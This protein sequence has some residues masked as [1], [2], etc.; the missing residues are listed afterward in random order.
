MSHI[1]VASICARMGLCD[2]ERNM[3]TLRRWCV[4]ARKAGADL[5]VFPEIFISGYAENFMC[6][7]GYADRKTF[8]SL[9]EK[10]PG[11]STQ[12]LEKIASELKLFICVGLLENGG[13]IRYNTQ[14][15]IDPEKGYLG[16][17]RK[18]HVSAGEQWFSSPGHEW[19]VFDIA[20][21][22]TG[23]M[24]CRDKSHP[25]SARILALEG[26]CLLLAPHSCT[27]T[28][29]MKFTEWSRAICVARAMENGCYVIM[30]NNIY[31]CP[32]DDRRLQSGYT[33][34]IDPYGRT[35]HCD[36]GPGD[37][38]KMAVVEVDMETV[39]ARRAMEGP[40]SF[41]LWT[42]KPETYQ[43]LVQT[44]KAAS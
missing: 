40:G 12:I 16:C 9:A 34:A 14:V 17:Y 15:V 32:M 31:D 13:G 36:E 33:V 4:S 42:R 1:R 6:E 41:N 7:A 24:L 11:P 5:A 20:G 19:P 30:N 26:A 2:R 8:L 10:V 25:E 3:E 27:T 39:A 28:P 22:P 44:E 29:M 37:V 23:I 18:V 21:V 35:I 43:R 38:E